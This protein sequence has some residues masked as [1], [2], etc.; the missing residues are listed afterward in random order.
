MKCGGWE[1]VGVLLMGRFILAIRLPRN[2][3]DPFPTFT[4]NDT[5]AHQHR[6]TLGQVAALSPGI[7]YPRA[8][9]LHRRLCPVSRW[10]FGQDQGFATRAL[11]TFGAR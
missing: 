10:T 4:D 2:L 3:R 8:H 11:L 7:S 9:T 1:L 5:E 6:L